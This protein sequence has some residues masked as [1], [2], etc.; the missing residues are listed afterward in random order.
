M[1]LGLPQRLWAVERISSLAVGVAVTCLWRGFRWGG[2]QHNIGSGKGW[3]GGWHS[4]LGTQLS[5][6]L[7]LWVLFSP[8]EK[9]TAEPLSLMEQCPSSE[10]SWTGLNHDQPGA[11]SAASTPCGR[12]FSRLHVPRAAERWCRQFIFAFPFYLSWQPPHSFSFYL[13]EVPLP[14]GA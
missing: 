2:M 8:S 10:L 11:A 6:V 3:K 1:V 13:A 4:P 9:T 5:V 14:R 7:N 12:R